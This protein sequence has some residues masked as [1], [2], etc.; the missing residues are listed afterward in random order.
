MD[1]RLLY[2]SYNQ[3]DNYLNSLIDFG[4]KNQKWIFNL[5]HGF[6]PDIDYKKAKYVVNWIKEANWKR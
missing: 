5:G 6:I 4:S 1:P 2:S 3:I